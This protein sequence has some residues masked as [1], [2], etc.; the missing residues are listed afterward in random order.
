MIGI[1]IELLTN[2]ADSF[3]FIY[4]VLRYCNKTLRD[5]KQAFF[6][7]VLEFAVLSSASLLSVFSEIGTILSVVVVF[8]FSLSIKSTPLS[9]RITSAFI[10]II[11]IF[12]VNILTLSAYNM[13]LGN[14]PELV[15][16]GTA[17]R[18]AFLA[19]CKV[20]FTFAI[21]ITLKTTRHK[22]SFL[23]SDLVLY[24]LFPLVS[25]SVLVTLCDT[26]NT[27]GTQTISPWLAFSMLGI[28]SINFATLY[29]FER[30]TISHNEQMELKLLHAQL[31]YEKDKYVELQSLYE[32]IRSARHDFSKHMTFVEQLLDNKSYDEASE[33]IKTMQNS[34]GLNNVLI[35]SG[36]RTLD[37]IIN[38]KVS[39]SSDIKFSITGSVAILPN[40]AFDL[41]VLIGNM[42]DNAI[43]AARNSREHIVEIQFLATNYFQNI[44][45]RNSIDT[46]VLSINPTL[47]TTKKNT[48]YHGLGVKS[49]KK[50]AEK[51]LGIVDFFEEK[52]R[53]CIQVSLPI[54]EI[55][56]VSTA[57]VQDD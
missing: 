44:I 7:F 39:T 42:L 55:E 33:Y 2:A 28:I 34:G 49:I 16:Y 38:S 52:G 37:F 11:L 27:Y 45:C 36:N 1:L 25:F 29:L 23:L 48:E 17:A 8:L 41:V 50:I 19:S 24:I 15:I 4:F 14:I 13:L 5:A 12:S 18:Y 53:F 30:I 9:T 3:L 10:F 57:G 6:F 56:K 46:S 20:V 21:F 32:Q 26:I 35:Q 43:E 22:V 31:S 47:K 51:Y 54:C 40:E